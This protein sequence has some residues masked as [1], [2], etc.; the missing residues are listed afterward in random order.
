MSFGINFGIGLGT[1]GGVLL[2][3]AQSDIIQWLKGGILYDQNLK[4]PS[5]DTSRVFS[6]VDDHIDTEIIPS[7]SGSL[8]VVFTPS[9]T[10]A[11]F[12]TGAVDSGDT[13]CYI[14][15]TADAY[16]GGGVGAHTD[17]TIVGTT[18]M[19]SGNTYTGRLDWDGST[20]KLFL[21]GKLEY[22]AAQSGAVGTV[23]S[24]YVGTLNNNGT[25][26][27]QNF[28]GK[29]HRVAVDDTKVYDFQRHDAKVVN[30]SALDFNGT[31]AY[32]DTGI[33]P[34]SINYEFEIDM[35]W[36]TETGTQL[37]G[38]TNSLVQF[39]FVSGQFNAYFGNRS[40]TDGSITGYSGRH[41]FKLNKSG[42][43]I[44]DNFFSFVSDATTGASSFPWYCGAR[45]SSG[46]DANH[47]DCTTYA[48]R[49]DDGTRDVL[50][51]NLEEGFG[52]THYD[53]TYFANDATSVNT[54]WISV[55]DINSINHTL[56]FTEFTD[57]TKVVITK[58][59][60]DAVCAFVHGIDDYKT[61][62]VA[63][64]SEAIDLATTNDIITT[65][66]S[67]AQDSLLSAAAIATL[68]A[69]IDSGE[70][71]LCSHGLDETN[72]LT[73]TDDDLPFLETTVANS[74]TWLED[75]FTLPSYNRYNG[76]NKITGWV[77]S[78]GT[79]NDN[80]QA[81]IDT[82]LQTYGYIIDAATGVYSDGLR[83]YRKWGNDFADL[84]DRV[85]RYNSASEVADKAVFDDAYA[86]GGILSL[87]AH[88]ATKDYSPTGYMDE[89]FAYIG[90]RTD[91]WYAGLDHIYMYR[92]LATVA[93]PTITVLQDT[94]S[95][96]EVKIEASSAWRNKY[97]L[98]YPLTYRMDIPAA[99]TTV[100]VEYK[101]DGGSYAA[102]SS[103]TAAQVINGADS[104]RVDLTN[105]YVYVSQS[106]P[107]TK[108][109][110]YLKAEFS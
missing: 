42:L 69:Y 46:V 61:S 10:D 4:E 107:Q 106:L 11:G 18:V 81:I 12:I 28:G 54:T 19:V 14:S 21:N 72:F 16:L 65:V 86:D 45:N 75:N 31:N 66:A 57:D 23:E 32:L 85:E 60:D 39:G 108:N 89:V 96:L 55:D 6:S 3:A 99:A 101:E 43:W 22:S 5:T 50:K 76:S 8:E 1:G 88:P 90:G 91:V 93:H 103:H 80:Y 78:Y 56:G 87:Y 17:S 52:T 44:D 68:Q 41:V 27:S 20:V 92:L 13:R 67:Y 2:P 33:A 100:T 35:E 47:C 97:A 71:A 40:I 49:I 95:V 9:G 110:M 30:V 94:A 26:S 38:I 59:Y 102:M 34:S 104:Y 29:I 63:D 105:D 109:T 15:I 62:L 58:Y 24:I 51:L 64:F 73:L 98:S 37:V 84:F 48:V 79:A 77:Q 36:N 83:A 53:E 74:K 70:V 7:S 25:P 82:H